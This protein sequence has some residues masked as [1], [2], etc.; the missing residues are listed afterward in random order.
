M[1]TGAVEL[2]NVLNTAFAIQLPATAI[3]DY[4]TVEALTGHVASLVVPSA[5]GMTGACGHM[6]MTTQR[7]FDH[8]SRLCKGYVPLESLWQPPRDDDTTYEGLFIACTDPHAEMQARQLS[9]A[10]MAAPTAT[11]EAALPESLACRASTPAG[12]TRAAGLHPRIFRLPAA[13]LASGPAPS[14]GMTSQARCSFTNFI[15]V[16]LC[17]GS[18]DNMIDR[19]TCGV[20]STNMMLQRICPFTR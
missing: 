7:C 20:T 4:P 5:L 15:E 14:A 2:R 1:C 11:L 8:C 13:P 12:Q 6:S 10:W 9:S 17:H 18:G 16:G 3:M 19:H